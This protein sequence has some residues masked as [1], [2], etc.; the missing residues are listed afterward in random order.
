MVTMQPIIKYEDGKDVLEPAPQNRTLH[1]R[2]S[3][4]DRSLKDKVMHAFNLAKSAGQ[5]LNVTFIGASK[6]T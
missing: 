1:Q 6:P 2:I 4:S 3:V 5:E